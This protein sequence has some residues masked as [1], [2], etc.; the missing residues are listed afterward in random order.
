VVASTLA[1]CGNRLPLLPSGSSTRVRVML[2]RAMSGVAK[3]HRAFGNSLQR[4]YVTKTPVP[5]TLQDGERSHILQTLQQTEGVVGG[6]NGAAAR[7]GLRRTTLVSKMRRLRIKRGPTSGSPAPTVPSSE[8]PAL[9]IPPLSAIAREGA[10]S[11]KLQSALW[12]WEER[13]RWPKPKRRI[14]E[15]VGRLIA[16]EGGGA[17]AL[18]GQP[19]TTVMVGTRSAGR[20]PISFSPRSPCMFGAEEQG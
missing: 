11:G 13:T 5:L 20:E 12:T 6:P 7:L 2:G 17:A 14:S 4:S 16:G 10:S 15:V 19:K 3:L 1:A 18:E 9:R 8:D